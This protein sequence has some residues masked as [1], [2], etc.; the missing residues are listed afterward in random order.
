MAN[1]NIKYANIYINLCAALNIA[2]LVY[3]IIE[4]FGLCIFISFKGQ[5]YD[6]QFFN[7]SINIINSILY[8]NS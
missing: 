7:F 3:K 2:V 5:N 1:G 6:M 4:M 8:W